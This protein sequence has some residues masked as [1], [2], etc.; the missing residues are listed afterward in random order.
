MGSHRRPKGS[1][2]YTGNGW[3]AGP[4]PERGNIVQQ[5]ATGRWLNK[6]TAAL[7]GSKNGTG[8]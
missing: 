2:P 7:W 5:T 1:P 3:T 8:S 4:K 6:V